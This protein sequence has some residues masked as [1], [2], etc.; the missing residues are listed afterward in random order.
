MINEDPNLRQ[1]LHIKNVLAAY[2]YLTTWFLSDYN[3]LK[4]TKEANLTK[5]KRKIAKKDRT[6][7]QE[8]A[9]VD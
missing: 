5:N 4:E 7:D 8:R 6:T 3:K 1:A 9:E 2:V